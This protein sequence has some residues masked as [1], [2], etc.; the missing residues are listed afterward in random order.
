MASLLS[1]KTLILAVII[2]IAAMPVAM[3]QNCG[4]G[5]GVCC[6]RFGY[7]GNGNEYC[8]EGCREGP[9]NS[10]PGTTPSNSDVNVADLVTPQFFS[11]IIN[12]A[13]ASCPGKSFYT[14]DAFLNALNAFSG[15]GKIGSTDD[16]KRE[17]AAF[18][19]HVT[20]ETGHFC[21][22]EEQNPQSNYCDTSRT[23]YPCAQGKSYHGRGPLQLSWNYNYGA[24]GKDLN[25]D[26]LG[27]PESVANDPVLAFKTGLWF[28][29][30]NVRPV[31]TQGFG[32]T[33]QRINGAVECGGK[34]PQLVQAR[35]NYY[36]DYCNQFGV[37]PGGNLSC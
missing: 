2:A 21:Y 6:S 25:F 35:I 16:S 10:S 34:E 31:V 22:I 1:L 28:W 29:M 20:H 12:Q 30:N 8:G 18:F 19:A 26:G 37:S 27:S 11:G 3:G 14:R 23:D 15:F 5:A 32:A 17:I 4:C 7:C 33:I 9:C 36:T 24:A 13:A